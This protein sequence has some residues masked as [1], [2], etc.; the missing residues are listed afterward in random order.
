MLP[1]EKIVPL[2]ASNG[3]SN[4]ASA[5]GS[6]ADRAGNAIVSMLRQTAQTA[7]ENCERALG[8][9]NK[10]QGQLQEAQERNRKLE[11][12]VRHFQ[13]RA[14]RAEKWLQQIQ[15]EI[16]EGFASVAA[17]TQEQVNQHQQS[18]A[19]GS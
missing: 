18:V 17:E 1:N 19:I 11:A 14:Q 7:R 6:P 9:V 12:D 2:P 15:K 16:E 8:T 13:E 4:N 10:L 3:A 5:E